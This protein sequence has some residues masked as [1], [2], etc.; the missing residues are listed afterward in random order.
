MSP[1]YQILRQALLARRAVSA[2]YDDLLREFC[3]YVLGLKSGSENVL[4]YQYGGLSSTRL[5]IT[6][7]WRC[8]HVA[9]LSN[10]SVLDRPWTNEEHAQQP[11][12]CID[13][14]DVAV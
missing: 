14:V 12:S 3:P 1:E 13:D 9:K 5:P 4:V 11:Q 7:Q 10:L 8:F 6:G 2:M